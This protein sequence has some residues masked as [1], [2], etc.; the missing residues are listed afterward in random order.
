MLKKARPQPQQQPNKPQKTTQ[1]KKQTHN[2][3][4]KK[5]HTQKNPQQQP[6]KN[7]KKQRPTNPKKMLHILQNQMLLSIRQ[8]RLH[9]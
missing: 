1:H 5:I 8:N 4:L 3:P 9:N 7:H 2:K 6:N